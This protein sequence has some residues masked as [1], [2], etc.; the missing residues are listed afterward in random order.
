LS[1]ENI[2]LS[3]VFNS[4][5]LVTYGKAHFCQPLSTTQDPE[6][7]STERLA[8]FHPGSLLG[9]QILTWLSLVQNAFP[10]LNVPQ[11]FL[12]PT[13]RL[14]HVYV[15]RWPCKSMW[16]ANSLTQ[17]EPSIH[18]LDYSK[19]GVSETFSGE[20]RLI[21]THSSTSIECNKTNRPVIQEFISTTDRDKMCRALK[22]FRIRHSLICL[23]FVFSCLQL[24]ISDHHYLVLFVYSFVVCLFIYLVV[25]GI[26][27]KAFPAQTFPL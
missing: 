19:N 22:T 5:W 3:H 14:C 9:S 26:E 21:R 24:H 20:E 15:G 16:K 2:S 13:V 8:H 4:T 12:C 1:S 18:G 10:S 11:H 6:T 25:L 7:Q 23:L 17:A 27:P